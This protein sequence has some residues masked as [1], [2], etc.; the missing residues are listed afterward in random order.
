M[1]HSYMTAMGDVSFSS[2]STHKNEVPEYY[3]H[4]D[5]TPQKSSEGDFSRSLE[6]AC[7]C[8][9]NL[10]DDWCLELRPRS[11]YLMVHFE[12]VDDFTLF[13][14]KWEGLLV[15]LVPLNGKNASHYS[16]FFIN[17]RTIG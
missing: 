9:A 11:T 12:C 14:L 17:G 5:M 3:L 16:E 8:D 15:P 4:F 6:I 13:K 2:V 1:I 7:W 10:T